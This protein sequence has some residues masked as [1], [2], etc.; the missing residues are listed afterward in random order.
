MARGKHGHASSRRR[1]S[2]AQARLEALRGELEGEQAAL[3]EA[4]FATRAVDGLREQAR[5]ESIERDRSVGAQ[6]ERLENEADALN[7]A[8]KQARAT[9]LQVQQAGEKASDAV[10]DVVAEMASSGS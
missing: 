8:V 4:E 6:V 7:Q 1:A 2:L 10:I 3:A 5:T 9:S